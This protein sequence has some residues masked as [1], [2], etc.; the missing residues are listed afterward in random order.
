MNNHLVQPVLN[1]VR[2]QFLGLIAV[3]LVLTGSAAYAAAAKDSVTSRSIKNGAVKTVDLKDGA[4]TGPKIATDAVT[5]DNVDENTL[6]TVPDASSLGGL[7]AGSYAKSS[8][9]KTEAATDAGTALGDGTFSKFMACN[10]GDILLSGGPASL[11][12]TSDL[13]ESFPTPGS[14]NSWSARVDKNGVG[15]NWTVVILCL[16]QN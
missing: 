4:V 11:S 9:Y 10:A 1:L 14:T 2:T 6:G 5:G 16:D 3:L 12:S 15:D 7:G 13:I 8:V